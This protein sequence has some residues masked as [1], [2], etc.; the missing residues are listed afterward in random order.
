MTRAQR[1]TLQPSSWS[2]GLRRWK[3]Q[4]LILPTLIVMLTE[5]QL[6]ISNYTAGFVIT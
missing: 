5:K 6:F 3:E 1:E 4:L 2:A